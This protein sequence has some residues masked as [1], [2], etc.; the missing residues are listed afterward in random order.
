MD[1]PD[2]FLDIAIKMTETE[3][4]G[5]NLLIFY[6][7]I[8]Y[9]L[10]ILKGDIEV[11]LMIAIVDIEEIQVIEKKEVIQRNNKEKIRKILIQGA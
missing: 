10:V 2:T 5:I 1:H 4:E 11:V 3:G 7:L 6:P 8:L 9:H